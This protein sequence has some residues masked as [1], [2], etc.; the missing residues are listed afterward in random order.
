MIIDLMKCFQIKIF[1][2]LQ[3]L[4]NMVISKQKKMIKT[5]WMNI[6]LKKKIKRKI[7]K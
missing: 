5:I 1:I 6:I 3:K 7:K 4:I 2:L